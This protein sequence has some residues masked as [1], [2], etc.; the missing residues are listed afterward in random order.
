MDDQEGRRRRFII[1]ISAVF[2]AALIAVATLSAI[3]AH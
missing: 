1:L 2:L 3:A